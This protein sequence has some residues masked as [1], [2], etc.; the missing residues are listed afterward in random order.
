VHNPI[1]Q[2]KGL[3]EGHI[4]NLGSNHVACKLLKLHCYGM[5][6]NYCS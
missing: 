4:L 1:N 5:I 3:L 2:R 6:Q